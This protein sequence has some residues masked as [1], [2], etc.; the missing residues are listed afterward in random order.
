MHAGADEVRRAYLE[1]ARE[2]H[3]DRHIDAS[4]AQRTTNERRMQEVNEAWRVLGNPRRRRRYD[5]EQM[6][7]TLFAS[8]SDG[9]MATDGLRTSDELDVLG[10]VDGTTRLIRGLPWM[11]LVVVMFAIFVFTAYAAS[12]GD[13]TNPIP[14]NNLARCVT[15]ASATVAPAPCGSAGA[16]LVVAQVD[17]NQ[18]C[19]LGS[20]RLQ[21]MTGPTVY[22]LGV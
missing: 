3:P 11:I 22:C 15:V 6:P 18:Q 19:P 8:R 21:P 12:G 17:T 7:E 20:E 5:L 13:K 10:E 9:T 16:R 4:S 1:R 14:T 2:A